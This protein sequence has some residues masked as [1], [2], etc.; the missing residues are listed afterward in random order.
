MD[1][2]SFF[3]RQARKPTGLYGRFYMSR[4]FDKGNAEMNALVL[5]SM[6]ITGDERILEIGYGTG[7]MLRTVAERLEQGLVEGVDFSKAMSSLARKKNK[8]HIKSGKVKIHLG[9]FDEMFLEEDSFNKVYTVNTIYFWKEPRKTLWHVYDIL[10]P[11]GKLYIGFHHKDDM[12]KMPLNKDVFTYYSPLEMEEILTSC[13][14]LCNAT[15]LSRNAKTKPCYC[16]IATK[17]L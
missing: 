6:D 14:I 12:E 10:K 1:Y 7:T 9:D 5:D 8:K 17:G 16:A 2:F 15:I 13:G 3:S 11:G 4:I